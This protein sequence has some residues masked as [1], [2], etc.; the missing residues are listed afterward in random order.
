MKGMKTKRNKQISKYFKRLGVAVLAIAMAIQ[1]VAGNFGGSGR[2]VQAAAATGD[3]IDLENGTTELYQGESWSGS[4]AA[5]IKNGEKTTI[6]VD[7][8]GTGGSNVWGIQ[9]M[10]KDLALKSGT[11]YLVE[12][13]ITSTIDKEHFFLNKV[14]HPFY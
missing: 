10:V 8:F 5:M 3:Y 9:Y 6:T 4:S 11:E 13:D 14:L 7:N 12:F 2:Y 1:P